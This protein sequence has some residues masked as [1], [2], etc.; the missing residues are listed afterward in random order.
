MTS[1][2]DAS[3]TSIKSLISIEERAMPMIVSMQVLG[4][5][6]IWIGEEKGKEE[7]MMS[8]EIMYV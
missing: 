7:M 8:N 4:I 5:S 1:I 2:A 6:L 3:T